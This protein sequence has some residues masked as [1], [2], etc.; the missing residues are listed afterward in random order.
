LIFTMQTM[1]NILNN[2]GKNSFI[3]F[4]WYTLLLF[5]KILICNIHR[6]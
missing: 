5:I 1:D 2:S 6:L 4:S 3:S